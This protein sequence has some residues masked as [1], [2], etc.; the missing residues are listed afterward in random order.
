M[1]FYFQSPV[2][3]KTKCPMTAPVA[4]PTASHTVHGARV[5]KTT[6]GMYRNAMFEGTFLLGKAVK[7]PIATEGKVRL[8][9][10]CCWFGHRLKRSVGIKIQFDLAKSEII[11]N[12]DGEVISN[13]SL[14]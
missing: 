14:R 10:Y 1:E 4:K 9:T 2:W 6:G 5:I 13:L 8:E 11:D 12:F 3:D 7:Q